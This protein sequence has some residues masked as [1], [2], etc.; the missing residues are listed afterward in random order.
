MR[1]MLRGRADTQ[2][3]RRRLD[4]L[5]WEAGIG[6]SYRRGVPRREDISVTAE[7]ITLDYHVRR[8]PCNGVRYNEINEGAIPEA[9]PQEFVDAMAFTTSL[10]EQ[11]AK[12]F[13]NAR[14]RAYV[15]SRVT[16]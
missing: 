1:F 6:I 8:F 7:V 14:D 13:G 11:G 5:A 9:I 16:T 12:A 15:N 4:H 10:R 3:E 2:R